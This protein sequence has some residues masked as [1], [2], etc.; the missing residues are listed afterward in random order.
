MSDNLEIAG[1]LVRIVR[2]Q[3]RE[4]FEAGEPKDSCPFEDELSRAAWADGWSR[5]AQEAKP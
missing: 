2:Q 3:G 1:L 5:A 4:A